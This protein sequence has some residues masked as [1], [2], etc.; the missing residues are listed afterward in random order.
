MKKPYRPVASEADL[1]DAVEDLCKLYH[2]RIAH[3][4]TARTKT[5]WRTAVAGDGVGWPDVVVVGPAGVLYRELKTKTGRP[6][7]EQLVWLEALQRA[8][9]DAVI[10]RPED[11]RSGRIQR[12]LWQITGRTNGGPQ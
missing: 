11:L 9:Q 3:F 1:Y 2:L 10:W 4:R 7:A 12:E 6:T 8:G 5:G